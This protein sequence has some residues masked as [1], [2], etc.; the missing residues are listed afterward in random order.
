MKKIINYEK[1]ILFKTNIG[2]ICSISL[3]HDFTVD[4]GVLRGEFII[5]GEYKANELSINKEPFS[6]RLPLEYELDENV[7]LETLTYDIDNFEYTVKDDCL[8]V[9]IDFGVRYEE[10]LIVPSIPDI[11]EDDL[12]SEDSLPRF[13]DFKVPDDGV[14]AQIEVT[15]DDEEEDDSDRL[16]DA[17]KEIIVDTVMEEDEYVTY[18]VHIVQD[19]DTLEGLAKEYGTTIE[20]IKEYNSIETLEVK[21]KIIIP[22]VNE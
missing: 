15:L 18:H 21:S 7:D 6:Y 20:I 16:D 2:E 3:E 8:T 10:K 14:D 12:N 5:D 13:S 17:E 19:G 1:D 11:T 22:I 4:E 9:I